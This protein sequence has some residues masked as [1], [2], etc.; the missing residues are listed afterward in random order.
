MRISDW[1]SDVCSSD[2]AGHRSESNV[3]QLS[4]RGRF[5]RAG[6]AD[7]D[8]DQWSILILMGLFASRELGLQFAD[9]PIKRLYVRRIPGPLSPSRWVQNLTPNWKSALMTGIAPENGRGTRWTSSTNCPT[10]RPSSP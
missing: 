1:S 9:P 6:Q 4:R 2:L 8:R 3:R 5:S 10:D 7:P